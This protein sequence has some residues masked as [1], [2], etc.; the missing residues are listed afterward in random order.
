MRKAAW[1]PLAALPLVLSLPRPVHAAIVEGVEAFTS[2]VFQQ[3][4]SSFSGI[5]FRF[6]VAP[7]RLMT[8][9]SIVP[10]IEYWRNKNRVETFDIETA[11]KD[12][13][14]AAF[15]RYD[16]KR[17]GWQPFLGAGLGV[18]FLSSEVD[19]PSLG[20]NDESDTLIKGGLAWLAGVRF[21]VTEKLGNMLEIEHHYVPKQ[22]QLKI[23]WG[24]IYDFG[25]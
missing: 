5:G 13:T 3:E 15:L 17:E 14:M 23:N 19:A 22:S 7:P 16:W 21:G 10:S 1:M 6:R 4:Q 9:F 18:H 2:T 24:L 8:G 25:P 20:L 11:R 12:A